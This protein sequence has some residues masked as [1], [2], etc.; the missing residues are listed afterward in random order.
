MTMSPEASARLILN[1]GFLNETQLTELRNN[2]GLQGC[3]KAAEYLDEY[4]SISFA[5]Q[6]WYLRECSV[7]TI[8]STAVGPK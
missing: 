7:Y 4:I 1:G 2:V 8:S 5:T 6:T 3:I